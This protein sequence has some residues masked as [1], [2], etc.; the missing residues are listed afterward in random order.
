MLEF[1]KNGLKVLQI[2]NYKIEDYNQGGKI[3]CYE[4]KNS[5][6]ESGYDVKTLSFVLGNCD[7][8][9]DYHLEIDKSSFF[10]KVKDGTIADW[11]IC[12]YIIK[13]EILWLKLIKFIKKYNPDILLL[14]Q[15]FL[16]PIIK[17]LLES[18]FIDQRCLIVNSTHNIEYKLKRS[19]YKGV[20]N[21]TLAQNYVSIVRSI[22]ED[23]TIHSDLT[24]CVSENDHKYFKKINK[25]AH[26]CI[27]PN[28]TKKCSDFDSVSWDKRFNGTKNNWVFVASWHQ[29]NIEGIRLL[30]KAGLES[31]DSKQTKLWVL[32]SVVYPISEFIKEH[33]KNN[34]CSYNRTYTR[35]KWIHHSA[36]QL[37]TESKRTM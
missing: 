25:N 21:T 19:I 11:A 7:Q 20:F 14:E 6:L 1:S 10:D 5:L 4:I 28:G 24:F 15:P 27:F 16:W 31:L 26:S 13:N 17:K 3:R 8:L 2:T 35:S 22:E 29:P 23:V 37:S 34:S 12:D 30:I 18:G 9:K 33:N 36:K 32:G